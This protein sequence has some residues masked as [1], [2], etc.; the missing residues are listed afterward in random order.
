[1]K[2]ES[3]ITLVSLV[4]TIIV[5][6]IIAGITI[7]M[8]VGENGILNK[9]KDTKKNTENFMEGEEQD[10]N[11]LYDFMGGNT[12]NGGLACLRFNDTRICIRLQRR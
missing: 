5:L 8:T 12:V 9:A 10:I 11:E 6:I 1:M 2:R 7:N 3:G 4:I